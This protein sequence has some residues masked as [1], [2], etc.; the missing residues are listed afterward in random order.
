MSYEA[1]GEPDDSPFEAAMEAGWLDPTDLSKALID[2]MN[3][4]DRQ[5]NEEHFD[6]GHDDRWTKAELPVAAACYVIN[7]AILIKL[8]DQGIPADELLAGNSGRPPSDLWPWGRHWWKPGHPRRNL[9]KAAA[10]LL[11]EIE[12]IDRADA[13]ADSPA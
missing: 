3:E 6:T 1:W 12:R 5:M 10:L 8:L 9:V 11:A 2:V 13:E 7:A 4:R